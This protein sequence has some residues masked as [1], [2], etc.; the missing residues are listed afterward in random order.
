MRESLFLHFYG[1]RD[2]APAGTTKSFG[3]KEGGRRKA[4]TGK[5]EVRQEAGEREGKTDESS[6]RKIKLLSKPPPGICHK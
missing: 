4:G 1:S 6:K 3:G 2:R 5:G